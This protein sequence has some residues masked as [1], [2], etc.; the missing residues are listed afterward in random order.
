MLST[1]R[2]T[3]KSRLPQVDLRLEAHNL[4]RF[5]QNFSRDRLV[6]LP[7]PLYPWV[8]QDILMQS[9]EEGMHISEYMLLDK[10]TV[11]RGAV[12]SI[13]S[14]CMLTMMLV[15]N[16]IHS[17]LHPGNILVRWQLPDGWLL[18]ATAALMRLASSLPPEKVR[19]QPRTLFLFT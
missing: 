10:D 14:H 15:H 12:A 1:A 6:S 9:F 17:D 4:W 19:L 2:A 16:L 3:S 5:N 13:G 7:M 8:S 11:R 18:S